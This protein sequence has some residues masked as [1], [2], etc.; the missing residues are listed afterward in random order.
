MLDIIFA[1]RD[2]EQPLVFRGGRTIS[3]HV[4]LAAAL[5]LPQDLATG[6]R[7]KRLSLP[8]QEEMGL[9]ESLGGCVDNVVFTWLGKG[10]GPRLV[11]FFPQSVQQARKSWQETTNLLENKDI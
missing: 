6:A 4:F 10:L 5:G 11:R 2:C 3:L 8:G 1:D 7:D 9:Q